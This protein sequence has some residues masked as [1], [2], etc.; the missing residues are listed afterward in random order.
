MSTDHRSRGDPRGTV[1][2]CGAVR[3]LLAVVGDY[4]IA[5][6]R[7]ELFFCPEPALGVRG[8]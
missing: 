2:V 5:I 7:S 3:G 1:G 4:W 6:G 8:A